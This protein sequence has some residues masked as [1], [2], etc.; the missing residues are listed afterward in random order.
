MN[1]K[2]LA[3]IKD[4]IAEGGEQKEFWEDYLRSHIEDV[5][6]DLKTPCDDC[7]FR[8]DVYFH[9]GIYDEL[10]TYEKG[11]KTGNFAHTCHK[12]DKRADGFEESYKKDKPQHCAGLLIMAKKMNKSTVLLDYMDALGETVE[13]N[14]DAPVFK[15]IKDMRKHYKENKPTRETFK[16]KDCEV[17]VRYAR[18]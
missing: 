1:K 10:D 18:D 11:L 15:S 2:L 16:Y 3:E 4:L 6:F 12:T 13:L 5:L 8:T 9:R 14:M 17:T 7:P